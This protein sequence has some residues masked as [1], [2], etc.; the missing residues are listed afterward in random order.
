[1]NGPIFSAIKPATILVIAAAVIYKLGIFF[2]NQEKSI[3]PFKIMKIEDSEN[4]FSTI[5]LCLPQFK[6]SQKLE[7]HLK[8]YMASELNKN[9]SIKDQLLDLQKKGGLSIG[10][11]EL[12]LIADTFFDHLTS[13]PTSSVLSSFLESNEDPESARLVGYLI[14]TYEITSYPVKTPDQSVMHIPKLALL[15]LLSKLYSVKLHIHKN[16]QEVGFTIGEDGTNEIHLMYSNLSCYYQL[17]KP[18][19]KIFP[20]WV[21]SFIQSCFAK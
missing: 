5:E 11:R 16:L 7:S 18:V 10:N 17:L 20:E 19:V 13:N 12:D 3:P 4:I 14:S 6:L 9:P 15:T 1:M 2:I 8:N 21:P